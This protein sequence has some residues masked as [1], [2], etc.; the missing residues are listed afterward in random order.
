[1]LI[2]D[3]NRRFLD[4]S[5]PRRLSGR[6]PTREV[7][8]S[9]FAS[10]TSGYAALYL[11]GASY[12]T[13]TRTPL[14]NLAGWA[15]GFAAQSHHN[16]LAQST[17]TVD[18]GSTALFMDYSS[19]NTV[20]QSLLRN[21]SGQAAWIVSGSNF[22]QIDRST[23]SAGSYNGLYVTWSSYNV[24]TQ[25]YLETAGANAAY[26]DTGANWN[27]LSWSSA[28]A[29]CAE[30]AA[31]RLTQASSNTLTRNMLRSPS[32]WGAVLEFSDYN[33]LSWSTAAAAGAASVALRISSC[34]GTVIFGNH[35]EG[36]TAAAVSGSSQTA[37][38]SNVL[39]ALGAAGQGVSFEPG[40]AGLSM[41]S[42]A[43]TG[44]AAGA[45]LYLGSGNSG[46]IMVSTNIFRSG[47]QYGVFA[48]T[49]ASGASVWLTSNTIHPTL[50][51]SRDTYGIYFDG[52]ATGATVQN[53]GVYYRGSGSMGAFTSFALKARSAR[54][55]V[56]ERNRVSQPGVL[57]GGSYVGV[58][59][60]DADGSV[61]RFMTF[62]PPAAA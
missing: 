32:G 56:I 34:A 6:G 28:S 8:Q 53:N 44:G 37:L 59:F 7:D 40:N 25:S 9:S 33:T 27:T 51:A 16:T 4:Q 49:Q 54:G 17:M 41:S 14:Y 5:G 24:V 62:M 50:S 30:C 10:N 61:V 19:S 31:A 47:G 13:I 43:V 29:N 18:N 52:L 39:A 12:A 38:N 11:S 48:A 22:N 3:R 23:L 42:N 57:T 46:L 45:G 55:L 60:I 21:P 58:D 26:F 36:S 35:I 20:T 15:A 1:M 2:P